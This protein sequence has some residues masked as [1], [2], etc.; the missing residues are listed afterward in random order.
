MPATAEVTEEAD[1][2][3]ISSVLKITKT[4]G[5]YRGWYYCVAENEAGKV[6]SQ[7]VKLHVQGNS[8]FHELCLVCGCNIIRSQG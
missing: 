5:Y 1:L 4:V 3:E 6:V 7:S 8:V 2:N